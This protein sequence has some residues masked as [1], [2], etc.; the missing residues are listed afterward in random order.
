[1]KYRFNF[2]AQQAQCSRPV[3]PGFSSQGLVSPEGYSR[4]ADWVRWAIAIYA[5][6]SS[7]QT[8]KEYTYEPIYWEPPG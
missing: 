4:A 1:M 7:I 8:A 3:E 5:H 2:S 6:Y